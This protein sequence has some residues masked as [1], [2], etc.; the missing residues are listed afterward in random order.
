[1]PPG[2]AIHL[3]DVSWD[4]YE[5][6]LAEIGDDFR[7]RLSYDEGR[8]EIMSPSF[9]HENISDHFPVL[10]FVLATECGL[11]YQGARSTTMRKKSRGKGIEADNSY[12]F[13]NLAAVR[14]KKQI[15]LNLDPPPD[16]ALEIDITSPSLKKLD[17]YAAIG[18]PE[19]WHYRH[20]RLQFFR[21]ENGTYAEITHSDLFPFLTPDVFL[22]HLRQ[23]TLCDITEMAENFH[24]WVKANKTP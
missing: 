3:Q 11:K 16:L 20:Q 10:I 15:D 14:G 5:N 8:L 6:Y 2:S 13:K 12:Y 21:L 19:L 18:V 17:I 7:L 23:G 22:A 1:M 9:E 24:A 4:D